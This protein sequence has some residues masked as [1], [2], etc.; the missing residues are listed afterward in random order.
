MRLRTVPAVACTEVIEAVVCLHRFFADEVACTRQ[1]R[2]EALLV[3]RY[4]G[5]PCLVV[6][7]DRCA[8]LDVDGLVVAYGEVDDPD[9]ELRWQIQ[10][11]ELSLFESS[12]S[13][14]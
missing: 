11:T 5:N 7:A 13:I 2:E 12:S 3:E 9:L 14:S 4:P 6:D 1:R 10:K 8:Q